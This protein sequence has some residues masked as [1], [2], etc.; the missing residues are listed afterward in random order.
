MQNNMKYIKLTIVLLVVAGALGG[1][2][3]LVTKGKVSGE[4]K[5]E[6]TDVKTQTIEQRI[7]DD[8]EDASNSSFCVTAYNDIL[9]SINLF[10]QNEPSNKATYT[11]MLQGA[12]CRKFVRQANAVFDGTRWESAKITTIRQE[13]NKCLGFFPDDPSLDSIRIILQ[14]YANLANFNSQVTQA[15]A[16]QPKCLNDYI[17]LY[18]PDNWDVVRTQRLLNN[19]PNPTGKVRNAPIYQRTRNNEVRRRLKNAHTNFIQQKMER[20]KIEVESYNYNPAR[21]GDYSKI[22]ERLYECFQSYANLWNSTTEFYNQWK[23]EVDSWGRYVEP[24]E[25]EYN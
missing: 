25:N 21:L 9:N 13:M 22:G 11:L 3:T 16:Q 7:H 4:V 12:Y 18:Q 8:I 15:C 2:I 5:P 6:P 14:N 1:I 24:L 17:Y 10:F 20:S 19:I 23:P